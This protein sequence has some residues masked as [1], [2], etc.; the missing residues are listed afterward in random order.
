[1]NVDKTSEIVSAI[2]FWVS[3]VLCL[4]SVPRKAHPVCG[5]PD[6]GQFM[7]GLRSCLSVLCT[8]VVDH[9]DL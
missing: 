1:M 4:D 7:T 9:A 2:D 3:Q 6:I 5:D 8:P